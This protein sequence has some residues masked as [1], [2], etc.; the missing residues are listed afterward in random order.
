[1][2]PLHLTLLGGFQA[3]SPAD[4][5]IAIPIKK[6]KALLAYLALHP[7][8]LHPRDKLAALLWEDSGETQARHSLRQALVGLRKAFPRPAHVIAAEDDALT[9]PP[10]AIEVDVLTFERLLREGTPEALE[11]AVALYQGELLEGF[12]PGAAGFEE[13]LME[14]RGR[15]RERVIAAAEA[16]LVRQ[17]ADQ[18]GSGAI[19]LALRLVSWDPLRESA[20][21]TLMELYAR[22]GRHGAALKQYQICHAVLRRELGVEPDAQT[23]TLHQHI[24]QQRRAATSVTPLA[25]PPSATTGGPGE[26]S[27]SPPPAPV[28]TG[29]EAATTLP[30]ETAELR[31]ASVLVARLASTNASE[32]L[33]LE[34]RHA[35]RQALLARVHAAS[36]RFGGCLIQQAPDAVMVVFGIPQARGNEAE[37]AVRAALALQQA[38][39]DAAPSRP[40]APARIGLASG[41]VLVS[42]WRAEPHAYTVTGDAVQTADALC[43]RAGPTETLLA[44]AVYAS[45]RDRVA[46]ENLGSETIPGAP[47]IWRLLSP[48]AEP[49]FKQS[50]FVG[51]R[52]PLRQLVSALDSCHETGGGQVVLVRGEAGIGKTR[53]VE[54]CAALAKLRGFAGHRTAVLDFGVAT[55]QEALSLLLRGLLGLTGGAPSDQVQ[56]AAAQAVA[57]K[58][59]EREQ[60]LFLNDLLGVPPPADRRSEY[61]AMRHEARQQGKQTV[62]GRLVAAAAARQPRLL[63]VEDIHWADAATLALL[64]RLAA[65]TLDRPVLLVMTSRLEGEPLDPAWRGAMHGAALLTLDLGPLRPEEALELTRQFGDL[66]ARWVARCLERAGG[67]PL[68]LEQ[69]LHAA[70]AG[71]ERVPDSVQSLIW[72]ALDRLPPID[73]AAIQAAAILGQRFA[74]ITLRHLLDDPEYRCDRLVEHRLARPDDDGYWFA[75]PLI[76]QG[77]Y[78]SLR[79]TRQRELHQRAAAWFAG[80]DSR[81]HAEHLERAG[82][83]TAA[84]AYLAAARDQ[85]GEQRPESALWLAGRGLALARDER[86]GF[87]LACLQGEML[88]KLGRIDG[89]IA[90]FEQALTQAPTDAERTRAWLGMAQGLEIQDRYPQALEALD[91]AQR[92]A[93]PDASADWLAQI[94]VQR[95]NISFPLGRLDACFREHEL[96]LQHARAAGSPALEARALSGL[97]DACYQRGRMLSA[98]RHFDQCIARCREHG[99]VGIEA[100]NLVMLGLTRFYQNDLAG[101]EREVMTAVESATRIGNPRDESLAFDVLGLIYQ[102][103]G[104]WPEARASIERSLELA[105]GLGARR[106]EAE[107]LGHLTFVMARLDPNHPVEAGFERA[108]TLTQATGAAY[109]GPWILSLWALVTDDP[110]RRARLLAEGEA[111]LGAGSV[112]HNYLHFYQNAMEAA[113]IDRDWPAVERHAAALTAYTAAEPLPWSAF[114]IARAR[115]L[116]RHGRGE[117]PPELAAIFQALLAQA[118]SAGLRVAVPALQAVLDRQAPVGDDR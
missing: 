75:H 113:L 61:A 79:K 77:I 101:A 50:A 85:A 106:F 39:A 60:E 30:P 1:M 112:G 38:S 25:S 40:A 51:R 17:L 21:R 82:D 115:A 118:E 96:A 59:I 41:L 16:L 71:D 48:R 49:R 89:S 34:N 80:R 46:A 28:H 105:R 109:M 27:T 64:A 10:P 74:S 63:L 6:A 43:N 52:A 11:Q 90:A 36:E 99:L 72:A 114:F 2:A 7:G 102:Y 54:E 37:R 88:R 78:A 70:Q 68:F 4:V 15:L 13:W 44:D 62:V 103:E 31:Q 22:Q 67:N 108:W 116:A 45:L 65:A 32:T 66:D 33:D 9:I 24:L 8:Q 97:G 19:G 81:L 42:P 23:E 58:I 29:G 57:D 20:Q 86:T 111:L 95:G 87:E 26:C 100:A 107:S 94:H 92:C 110:A 53:L 76:Q 84:R 47:L 35:V 5:A 3:R 91:Q 18:P 69:L 83:A 56:A 117:R 104:R 98:H 93:G 73:R 14:R 12:N 55:D